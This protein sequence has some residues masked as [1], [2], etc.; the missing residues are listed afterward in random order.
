MQIVYMAAEELIGLVKPYQFIAA[1]EP[2][3]PQPSM[4]ISVVGDTCACAWRPSVPAVHA[5]M[6]RVSSL[7][8]KSFAFCPAWFY[9]PSARTHSLAERQAPPCAPNSRP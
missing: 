5:G 8:G 3:C 9:P 6:L 2:S 4:R 1:S 7:G